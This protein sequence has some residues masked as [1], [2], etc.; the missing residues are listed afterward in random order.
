M[1]VACSL[2]MSVLGNAVILQLAQLCRLC[3]KCFDCRTALYGFL[4]DYMNYEKCLVCELNLEPVR[5]GGIHRF[6]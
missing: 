3:V 2:F 5:C 1:L 6:M 4:V